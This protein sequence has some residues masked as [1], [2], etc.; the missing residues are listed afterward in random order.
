M[1]SLRGAQIRV[2]EASCRLADLVLRPNIY[3]DCWLDCAKP[4]K[5]IAL[6]REAA[7]KQLDDIKKLAGK[8]EITYEWN[9]PSD[10]VATIA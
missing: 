4:G 10:P 9:S 5:F 6:G 1:R 2:A 7:E 8:K 3:D